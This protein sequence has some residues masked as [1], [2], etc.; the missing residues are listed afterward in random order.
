MINEFYSITKKEV[1]RV[2]KRMLLVSTI[3]LVLISLT[4]AS[5][6][7]EG[8]AIKVQGTG[9]VR[10]APTKVQ[11]WL[12]AQT[13]GDTA[14]Q[15]L[16]KNNDTIQ[17]II[18]VFAQ[19]ASPEAIKTSE[20]N[21]YQR[22]RW[23]EDE[24]KSMP[25]GFTVRQVFEVQIMDISNI[26]A[27]LDQVAGAGANIIYGLQYGVQD[28]RTPKQ[29]A[30]KLAMEDAWWKARLL[31]E[32]NGASDLVLESVEETY[33]YGSEFGSAA[34]SLMAEK[35]DTFMP[36]QLRVSVSLNATFRGKL[37]N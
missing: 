9:D 35:S 32:A 20:F 28:Y 33:Y 37:T 27:F 22:E 21:M 16:S 29:E 30:F 26:G 10:V 12:G 8:F 5:A 13:D 18:K 4:S 1:V 2:A 14:E 36:G 23:D 15:A 19:F 6:Y 31:A 34:T 3:F 11:M 24:R 7:A 25:D 17:S